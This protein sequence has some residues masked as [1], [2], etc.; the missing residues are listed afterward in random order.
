VYGPTYRV[1]IGRH[2]S[3]RPRLA[4]GV[5]RIEEVWGSIVVRLL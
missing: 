5:I 2:E 4:A 1:S 3:G